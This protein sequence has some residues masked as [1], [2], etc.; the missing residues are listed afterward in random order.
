[1]SFVCPLLEACGGHVK[2][3]GGCHKLQSPSV[4][5]F[6]GDMEAVCLKDK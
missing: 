5:P 6:L 3:F 1:M 2:Y 4:T